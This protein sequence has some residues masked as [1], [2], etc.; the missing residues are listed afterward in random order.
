MLSLEGKVAVVTGGGGSGIG[1]GISL[2]LARQGARVA[3]F[4]IDIDS[5]E[6]ARGRIKAEGGSATVVRADVSRSDNVR[7][8]IDMVV[9]E[10]EHLDI[11][12]N[13][14]GIGL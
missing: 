2:V 14:A 7:R 3:I 1:H 6:E 10:H 4:E 5:A 13:N 11:L 12:V 8:A 9:D